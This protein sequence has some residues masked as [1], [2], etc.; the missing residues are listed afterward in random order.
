MIFSKIH[1]IR[2]R[3]NEICPKNDQTKKW[4]VYAIFINEV[5]VFGPKP[6][7]FKKGFR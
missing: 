6:N 2:L 3:N 5:K 1:V 4:L 7:P